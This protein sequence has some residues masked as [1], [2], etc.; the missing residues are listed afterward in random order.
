MSLNLN[1]LVSGGDKYH[2]FITIG[3]VPVYNFL[4][5]SAVG[6]QLTQDVKP[7]GAIGS[8]APIAVKRGLKTHSF[9]ISLQ[10]GEAS[11][12]V[13]S[14][15]LVL[16]SDI[17]DF[18]DFPANTNITVV[19]LTDGFTQKFAGCTFSNESQNVERNSLETITE[20]SGT[21]LDYSTL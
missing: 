3:S 10:A 19:N 1:G 18:R 21:S 15:K 16:G 4:T 2:I 9:N 5:A 12:I 11:I 14:A 6:K 7:I 13:R 17:H 8:E 20:L